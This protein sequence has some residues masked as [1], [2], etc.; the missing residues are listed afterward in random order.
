MSRHAEHDARR[1][2]GT[3]V[4]VELDDYAFATRSAL[5]ILPSDKQHS[6][7]F[8]LFHRNLN[9]SLIRHSGY[10]SPSL[11]ATCSWNITKDA[12]D[13]LQQT[14]ILCHPV[15]AEYPDPTDLGSCIVDST[16]CNQFP[17]N[18]GHRSDRLYV[19]YI[20]QNPSVVTSETMPRS[21]T[22]G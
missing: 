10:D 14:P 15:L 5:M 17:R 4:E 20:S 11:N 19:A 21:A 7:N 6:N 3:N 18:Q 1:R 22:P 2:G 13:A 12:A 16:H 8:G 9:L